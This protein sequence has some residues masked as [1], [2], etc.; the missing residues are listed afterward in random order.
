MNT[1]GMKKVVTYQASNGQILRICPECEK[2]LMAREWPRNERG[3]EYA[4][5]SQGLHYY[6]C[7]IC[8][9]IAPE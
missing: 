9:A 3:E 2:S 5:V 8:Q 7:D 1:S 6:Y 4:T